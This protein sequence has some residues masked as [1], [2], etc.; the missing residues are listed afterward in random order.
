MQQFSFIL[1][2]KLI[3]IQEDQH[4]KIQSIHDFQ[5][6][7]ESSVSSSHLKIRTNTCS[8]GSQRAGGTFG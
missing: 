8:G 2:I 7:R 4:S 5:N 6:V 3:L 1:L